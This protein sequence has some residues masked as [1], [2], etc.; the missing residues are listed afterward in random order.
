[1][2]G[3]RGKLET[4]TSWLG[5]VAHD[6][7]FYPCKSLVGKRDVVWGFGKGFG[8]QQAL[9]PTTIS[10]IDS[11][12]YLVQCHV[13][14]SYQSVGA[15]DEKEILDQLSMSSLYSRIDITCACSTDLFFWNLNLL[16]TIEASTDGMDKQLGRN[17]I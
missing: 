9:S 10:F 2:L 15:E 11:C 6:D 4:K 5:L 13:K 8:I 12:P 14:H 1:M 16:W 17:K 7:R 3:Y